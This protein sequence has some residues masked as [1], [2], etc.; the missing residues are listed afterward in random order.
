MADNGL[1]TETFI[2]IQIIFPTVSH[3]HMKVC[4]N[5]IMNRSLYRNTNV[6]LRFN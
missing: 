1:L 4:A 3:L 5:F 2:F 6:A